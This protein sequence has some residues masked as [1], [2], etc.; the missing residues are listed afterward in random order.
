[1]TVTPSG[2]P[3]TSFPTEV[4]RAH[5]KLGQGVSVNHQSLF[6]Q[7]LLDYPVFKSLVKLVD[8]FSVSHPILESLRSLNGVDGSHP[9]VSKDP[10]QVILDGVIFMT[11]NQYR[12]V[13]Q[14]KEESLALLKKMTN[15]QKKRLLH[16]IAMKA[17]E[18]EDPT[19]L[20]TAT[21]LFTVEELTTL[22]LMGTTQ[23]VSMDEVIRHR[24]G[25]MEV[26]VNGQPKKNRPDL[27]LHLSFFQRLMDKVFRVGE[28]VFGFN[29]S[30]QR[31]QEYFQV[32]QKLEL[33]FKVIAL[34][35]TAA[36]LLY[37][38]FLNI[39]VTIAVVVSILAIG[40][41]V[42]FSYY[43]WIKK[44]P[45]DLA[46]WDN[47]TDPQNLAKFD[48]SAIKT[49][50]FNEIYSHVSACIQNNRWIR[51]LIIGESGVGKTKIITQLAQQIYQDQLAMKLYYTDGASLVKKNP[52]STSIQSLEST[53][54]E[55][56]GFEKEALFTI[57]EFHSTA[58]GEGF[59][60]ENFKTRLMDNGVKSI[61]CIAVTTEKEFQETLAKDTALVRRFTV[62][63]LVPP[64]PEEL[65]LIVSDYAKKRT[66]ESH[67]QF[68]KKAIQKI[69]EISNQMEFDYVQPFRATNAI[70]FILTRVAK[71][72]DAPSFEVIKNEE[73]LSRLIQ[74]LLESPKYDLNT[75][76]GKQKADEM[77]CLK[78]MIVKQKRE[79]IER[80]E[81]LNQLKGLEKL[82]GQQQKLS[83]Q[84]AFELIKGGKSNKEVADLKKRFIATKFFLYP[85]WKGKKKEMR[86]RECF[87]SFPIKISGQYVEKILQ[88]EHNER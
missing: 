37:P 64:E 59:L 6:S 33:Y 67:I 70:D 84:W 88:E 46:E 21:S 10:I 76:F 15:E 85:A 8:Y 23:T 74:S 47:L 17:L 12:Y 52:F 13:N 3:F 29:D 1:M 43:R 24:A 80:E 66:G 16:D 38:L 73:S 58:K 19:L 39:W 87:S 7:V 62:I 9:G 78:A 86:A 14:I 72:W 22:A 44:C 65:Q 34:P 55:V 45:D 60:A 36:A 83:S 40:V 71:A 81:L 56:A 48:S 35:L 68:S 2:L 20:T 4:N 32:I 26:F 79:I 50:Q 54:K 28:I 25:C 61:H 27:S 49:N 30:I 69:I 53:L 51:L 63:R 5:S 82:V 11:Y 18:R 57:D 75:K 42:I 77:D 31:H 41:L